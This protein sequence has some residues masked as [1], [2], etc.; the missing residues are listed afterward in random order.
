MPHFRKDIVELKTVY[1]AVAE[2]MKD[3]EQILYR[4]T[5]KWTRILYKEMEEG[6]IV[7]VSKTTIQK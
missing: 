4:N 7:E 2:M 1:R 5:T 3:M 6:K